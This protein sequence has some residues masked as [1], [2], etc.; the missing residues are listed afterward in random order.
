MPVREI[1]LGAAAASGRRADVVC[2]SWDS[3]G[4]GFGALMNGIKFRVIGVSGS[5]TIF[6]SVPIKCPLCHRVVKGSHRCKI[7][8]KN[9]PASNRVEGQATQPEKQT[10]Q[11]RKLG[12]AGRDKLSLGLPA[13]PTAEVRKLEAELASAKRKGEVW[14]L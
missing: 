5:C 14:E 8:P 7:G 1:V 10:K 2:A 3:G 11:S 4:R 9:F 13:V 12:A 6:S